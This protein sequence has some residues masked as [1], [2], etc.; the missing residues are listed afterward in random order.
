MEYL[1]EIEAIVIAAFNKTFYFDI[2][3]AE[4]INK[5]LDA[6]NKELDAKNKKLENNVMVLLAKLS[7]PKG[8]FNY[9]KTKCISIEMAT[10]AG[11]FKENLKKGRIFSSEDY[12]TIEGILNHY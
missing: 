9:K 6:K 5:E 7:K 1:N 11:L 4:E 2:K 12:G 10:L 8:G 3:R